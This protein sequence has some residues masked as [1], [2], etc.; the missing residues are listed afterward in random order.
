MR[1]RI[2]T[3]S[4]LL[5]FL[6]LMPATLLFAAP[7]GKDAEK[8]GAVLFR[9]KGCAYCHGGD[10]Q[11]TE[12]GPSLAD[13]RKKLTAEQITGQIEKGGMK[14]PSFADALTEDEV[15]ELVAFLR[16]RHRPAI[17]P[18]APASAPVSN[19]GR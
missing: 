8:A 6:L 11:G 7:T 5:V 14:M 15:T 19:P 13:V 12:K 16:S 18:P 10:A 17:P 2:R 3:F 1:N 9:S 4:A